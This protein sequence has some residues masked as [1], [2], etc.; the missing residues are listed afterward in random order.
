MIPGQ[1]IRHIEYEITG[2]CVELN[3]N[4]FVVK[5]DGQDLPLNPMA[6][7]YINRWEGFVNE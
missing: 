4:N 7:D 6:I 1:R 5:L 2:V 3:D